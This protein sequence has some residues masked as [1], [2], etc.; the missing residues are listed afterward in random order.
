MCKCECV[1]KCVCVVVIV[2]IVVIV[3]VVVKC[4]EEGVRSLRAGVTGSGESPGIDAGKQL[5]SSVRA[6]STLTTGPSLQAPFPYLL[7]FIQI[8]P[9]LISLT[10][11]IF[12]LKT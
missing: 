1:Y 4:S 9:I 10:I 7:A 6:A 11:F 2:V 12:F 3:I 5:R 8:N